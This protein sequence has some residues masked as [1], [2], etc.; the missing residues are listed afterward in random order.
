MT[1]TTGLLY[2]LLKMRTLFIPTFHHLRHLFYFYE[3]QLTYTLVPSCETTERLTPDA[4]PSGLEDP[5]IN[6]LTAAYELRG[7][8]PSLCGTGRRCIV[9]SCC[10]LTM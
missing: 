7:S 4:L 6:I 8:Q 10:D 3:L 9:R 1:E 5:D 2:L